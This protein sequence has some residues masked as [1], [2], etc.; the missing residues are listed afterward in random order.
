MRSGI[1]WVAVLIAFRADGRE[2][3]RGQGPGLGSA[4][5]E[6]QKPM[7][8]DA[9]EIEIERVCHCTARDDETRDWGPT[10]E[11]S[12][13]MPST[14]KV[15]SGQWTEIPFALRYHRSAP[16]ELDFP[17]GEVVYARGIWK[18]K[19]QV[20]EAPCAELT[21]RGD[22]VRLALRPGSTVRGTVSW[23]AS[24]SQLDSCS[25]LASDL[26]PGRYRVRFASISGQP[27]LEA[28]AELT[29]V[30]ARRR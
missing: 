14:W 22:R 9:A 23:K 3:C 17:R 26:A 20:E 2:P 4:L 13:E 11:L 27:P 25:D 6:K 21:A 7:P 18:G 19:V 15:A 10:A 1:V 30:A 8:C 5:G 24:T 28:T 29:V 12:L 16:A